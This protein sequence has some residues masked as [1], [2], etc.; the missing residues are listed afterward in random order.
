MNGL[1]M[2]KQNF[3]FACIM[4]LINASLISFILTAYNSGFEGNFMARWGINFAIAFSIVVPSI[5]FIGPIV[6]QFV[7]KVCS[8]DTK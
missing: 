3:I 1:E 8:N 4:A 6:N 7:Q 5:I 2:K